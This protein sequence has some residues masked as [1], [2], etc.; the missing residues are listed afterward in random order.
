MARRW[1]FAQVFEFAPGA[2]NIVDRGES[3][4]DEE[5][6]GFDDQPLSASGSRLLPLRMAIAFK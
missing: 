5:E 6:N 3:R 2:P 4:A 1:S